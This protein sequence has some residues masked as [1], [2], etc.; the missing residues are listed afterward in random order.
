MFT[1]AMVA[2]TPDGSVPQA[3]IE[4]HREA[5]KRIE[6]IFGIVREEG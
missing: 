3:A 6:T 2:A 5:R 1:S 4:L